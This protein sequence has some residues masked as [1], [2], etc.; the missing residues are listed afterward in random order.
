MS[1]KALTGFYANVLNSLNVRT[2][3]DSR[4][5][6]EYHTADGDPILKPWTIDDRRVVLPTTKNLKEQDWDTVIAF[7]PLSENILRGESDVVHTLKRLVWYRL[8]VSVYHVMDQLM[9]IAANS[10]I[11][12]KLNT[13]QS[14]FLQHVPNAT[15]KTLKQFRK[16]FSGNTDKILN[17]YLKRDG[18][19]EGENYRRVAVVDFPFTDD[20]KDDELEVLDSKLDSKKSKRTINALID[21]VL[22]HADD[23][24]RWSGAS[25]S[26]VA[27]YFDALLRAYANVATRTNALINIFKKH[28]EDH[29]RY[30][31]D[32]DWMDDLDS[33]SK[34]R[35][36]IP[37]MAYNEG[38]VPKGQEVSDSARP[39][40]APV[41]IN[42]KSSGTEAP[43]VTEAT[44]TDTATVRPWQQAPQTNPSYNYNSN[45][46]A[47]ASQSEAQGIQRTGNGVSWNSV[48]STIAPAQAAQQSNPYLNPFTSPQPQPQVVNGPNL[49][50][51]GVQQTA[52]SSR[53]TINSP[54]GSDII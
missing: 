25:N 16:V 21:Y 52:F 27:P 48:R 17:I 35:N 26:Q 36:V 50:G 30:Y 43:V 32:L 28:F 33:I 12:E 47:M 4:L 8:T 10:E 1:N 46:T 49:G 45:A 9:E 20:F 5:S 2:V 44:Q 37:A 42:T 22:P 19:L 29:E 38:A 54:Y 13:R 39:T 15:E 51:Y 14:K 34:W 41:D 23:P 3:E 11:H 40:V 6:L 18:V 31:I 7:H 24:D 53:Q